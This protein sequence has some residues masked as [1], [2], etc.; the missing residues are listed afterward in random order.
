MLRPISA[1]RKRCKAANFLMT[2]S[3][4]ASWGR[5]FNCWLR[6][7]YQNRAI[8][9]KILPFCRRVETARRPRS[10]KLPGRGSQ[11]RAK[12]SC[13]TRKPGH[14]GT[15]GFFFEMIGLRIPISFL[16]AGIAEEA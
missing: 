1:Q 8:H 13:E 14:A 10:L 6:S 5:F 3:G 15:P 2:A 4:R 16:S 9:I 12:R 7:G 11:A